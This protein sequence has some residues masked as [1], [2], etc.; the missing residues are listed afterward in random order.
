MIKREWIF[1]MAIF[2]FIV[3]LLAA[4]A[5]A[6][7]L[8]VPIESIPKNADAP[9]IGSRNF[10]Y[11]EIRFDKPMWVISQVFAFFALIFTIWAWQVKNKVRMMMLVGLFSAFLAFSATLLANF[12]LGVLF[13]LA[14]IR[15]FV[16]CYLDMKV[17]QGIHV[18]KRIPYTWAAVF[19]SATIT[20]T[21]VLV[22]FLKVD[23]YGAWLEWLI[24]L[25]LIGLIVGNILNGTNLMRV[26][27]ISN[28]VFNI[29]NHIYFSNL[30][31]V[32]IA[33]CAI[34]S[35]LVFYLREFIA[36]RKTHKAVTHQGVVRIDCGD[37]GVCEF[38][39]EL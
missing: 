18:P 32:I 35:N 27:F 16:F 11:S 5:A 22:Y 9:I 1:A 6:E 31:A 38:C 24:C 34:G 3:T 23:S 33:V 21:I 8:P 28:R 13:G 19:A 30:I 2:S 4:L 12:T 37:C 29:V 20:S 15:N 36:W 14:A 26:S 7:L 10:V 25:T 39:I 17:E